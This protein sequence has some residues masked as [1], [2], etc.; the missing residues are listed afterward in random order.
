MGL[1]VS[2]TSDDTNITT[3]VNAT[4][5]WLEREL[6]CPIGP[7]GD[8]FLLLDGNDAQ[9]GGRMIF[10]RQGIRTLTQ[11]E[12][13]DYTGATLAVVTSTDY[14]VRPLSH[15]RQ[16]GWPA[17]EIWFTDTPTGTYSRFPRGF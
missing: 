17:Q 4:N 6:E 7:S 3:F 11:L 16:T 8:T 14:F 2:D 15:N 10:V 13:G 12:V 1:G 5:E 9:V